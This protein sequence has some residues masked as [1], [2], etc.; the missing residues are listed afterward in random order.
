[1]LFSFTNLR[2]TSNPDKRHAPADPVTS[3]VFPHVYPC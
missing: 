3:T 1:M 2:S